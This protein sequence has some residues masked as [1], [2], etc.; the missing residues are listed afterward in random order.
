[1]RWILLTHPVQAFATAPAHY[2]KVFPQG[3]ARAVQP[4]GDRRVAGDR[5]RWW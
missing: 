5:H 3:N 2:R 4:L 1:M